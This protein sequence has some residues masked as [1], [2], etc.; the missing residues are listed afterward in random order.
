MDIMDVAL[1]KLLSL[2]FIK[3]AVGR[4]L[5]SDSVRRF[6]GS[7]LG[8]K[9][10]GNSPTSNLVLFFGASLDFSSYLAKGRWDL[11]KPYQIIL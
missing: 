5:R 6:I 10:E 2:A 9:R 3:L 4:E 1:I 11:F 7:I 8:F